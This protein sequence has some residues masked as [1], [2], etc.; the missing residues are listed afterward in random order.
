VPRCGGSSAVLPA[1]YRHDQNPAR[2]GHHRPGSHLPDR[3]G[4]GGYRDPESQAFIESWFRQFKK[5]LAWRSEWESLDQARREIA[6]YIESYQHRSHSGLAYRTPAEV[7]LAWQPDPDVLQT[8]SDLNRQHRWGPRH[9]ASSR[10]ALRRARDS[11]H[12]CRVVVVGWANTARKS[13]PVLVSPSVVSGLPGAG[14]P[15]LG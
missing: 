5:R 10:S 11:E 3:A 9:Q 2:R 1:R 6:G 8:P 14:R 4:R 15:V 12:P 7:A 13:R